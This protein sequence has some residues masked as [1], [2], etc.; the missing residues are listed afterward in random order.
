MYQD[1]EGGSFCKAVNPG[2]EL[3]NGGKYLNHGYYIVQTLLEIN[4]EI[5]SKISATCNNFKR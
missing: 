4:T 5:I 3:D 1:E 2:Y